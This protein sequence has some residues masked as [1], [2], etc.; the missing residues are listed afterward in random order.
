LRSERDIK[1]PD[2]PAL[3]SVSARPKFSL[4]PAAAPTL[5]RLIISDSPPFVRTP[6]SVIMQTP[7]ADLDLASPMDMIL[8]P[9]GD[10][11]LR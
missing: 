7:C 2:L 8:K 4:Q 9:S 5:V 10:A 1:E 6:S 11:G 3:S